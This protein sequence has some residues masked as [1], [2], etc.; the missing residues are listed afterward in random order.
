MPDPLSFTVKWLD[1]VTNCLS[2]KVKIGLPDTTSVPPRFDELTH[3][4]LVALW[5]TG[6]T[7]SVITTK[8]VEELG[9]APSGMA[10]VSGIL[11]SGMQN[12]YL[13]SIYLPSSVSFREVNVTECP[14]ITGGYDVIIGMD[15]ITTG[16]FSVTNVNGKTTFSFRYPSIKEIDFVA[17]ADILKSNLKKRGSKTNK[18]RN[19]ELRKIAKQ[20]KKKGRG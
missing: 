19:K 9:L 7:N 8:V 1:G 5:D 14:S 12:T 13:V 20:N 10:N 11:G 4:E 17:E 15:I 16:D 6:A 3:P 18:Q 2:H